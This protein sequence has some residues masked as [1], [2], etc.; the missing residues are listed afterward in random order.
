ME[1][2]HKNMATFNLECLDTISTLFYEFFIRKD[3]DWWYQV[4]PN[5]IV[6]DVGASIGMFTC[7]ALDKGAKKVY[8]IEP[9]LNLLKTTMYNATPHIANGKEVIPINCAISSDKNLV[10]FIHGNR[11]TTPIVVK[12]FKD[13]LKEYNIDRIDFLKIDCEGGEYFILNEEN[14]N[15]IKNNVKHIAVEVHLDFHPKGPELYMEF[16]DKFLVHFRDK[17]KFLHPSHEEL[18]FNTDWRTRTDAFPK[19]WML[20]IC[21]HNI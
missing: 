5:D 8:A 4:Q 9:N 14:L 16:R 18:T 10:T 3:Y 2:F 6:V 15:F 21:N 17:V 13:I 1:T 12:T 20:Y 7:S 19:W 11:D